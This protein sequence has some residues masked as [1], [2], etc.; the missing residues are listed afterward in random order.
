MM[1]KMAAEPSTA[2][3]R[4]ERAATRRTRA[5]RH[6]LG[7]RVGL[8][9]GTSTHCRSTAVPPSTAGQA[10]KGGRPCGRDDALPGSG[11]RSRQLPRPAWLPTGRW[12]APRV[13][14]WRPT[15][16]IWVAERGGGA[17]DCRLEGKSRRRRRRCGRGAVDR[18]KADG[19]DGAAAGVVRSAA[20][21]TEERRV[22]ASAELRASS[23]ARDR[24]RGICAR[25]RLSEGQGTLAWCSR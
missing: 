10:S 12:S 9:G 21:H 2:S 24:V 3:A 11:A 8:G 1:P 7:V 16:G 6:Q 5:N 17:G 14:G 4:P 18:L 19:V 23:H 20:G 22:K 13:G 25:R 15:G